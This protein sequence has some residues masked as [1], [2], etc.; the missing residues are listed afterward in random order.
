VLNLYFPFVWLEMTKELLEQESL[1]KAQVA[2]KIKV[3]KLPE[4]T[5]YISA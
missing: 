3:R 5:F 2:A 1:H 4:Q